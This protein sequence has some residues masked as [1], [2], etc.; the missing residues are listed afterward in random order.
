[1][2]AYREA[3]KRKLEESKRD[4]ESLLL[5]SL[6]PEKKRKKDCDMGK[7]G[8]SSAPPSPP[9]MSSFPGE[10]STPVRA[11]LPGNSLPP[12]VA[13]PSPSS[14]PCYTSRVQSRNAFPFLPYP[15]QVQQHAPPPPQQWPPHAYGSQPPPASPSLHSLGHG[16]S[17]TFTPVGV[18]HSHSVARARTPYQSSPEFRRESAYL[19]VPPG[20]ELYLP[21]Q[22][23][24]ERK[25]V[26]SYNFYS[27]PKRKAEEYM[28]SLEASM[29]MAVAPASPEVGSAL[30]PPTAANR[31]SH[32]AHTPVPTA[33][34][35]N[36]GNPVA[37][38]G[39][40]PGQT[41][42]TTSSTSSAVSPPP[43]PP[44][45]VDGS[46]RMSRCVMER[47]IR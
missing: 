10:P 45:L 44:P 13:T 41:P 26:I 2:D 29:R 20:M 19:P 1:M 36:P 23:G 24:R 40:H 15:G 8:N 4:S 34:P 9:P 46:P 31:L 12:V 35:D 37:A 42:A 43:P 32:A 11:R 14:P 17:S 5:A 25:Y 33:T 21:D 39:S 27:L 18:A 47:S 28:R 16:G 38:T 6:C 7:D 3:K 22:S 30:P